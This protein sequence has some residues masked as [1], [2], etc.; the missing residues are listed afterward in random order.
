MYY[1]NVDINYEDID[2]LHRYS[3]FVWICSS[4]PKMKMTTGCPILTFAPKLTPFSLEVKPLFV[5]L[6]A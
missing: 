6:R 5:S 2:G 4:Q 3:G 1:T